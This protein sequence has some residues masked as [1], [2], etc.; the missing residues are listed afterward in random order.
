MARD[1]KALRIGAQIMG[2]VGEMFR[3]QFPG[4]KA[5]IVANS[6]GYQRFNNVINDSFARN[7]VEMYEPY[8]FTEEVICAEYEYVERLTAYLSDKPDAV[9]VSIGAGTINDLTKLSS[10]KAGLRYMSIATA[11]SMDGYAS[12][13]ASITYQGEKKDFECDAPQAILADTEVIAK[14]PSILT[15]AGY[16]DLFAKVTA[17]AD[18]ILAEELGVDKIDKYAWSISQGG[19]K[20]ALADP[21]GI[22]K[23]NVNSIEMLVEGLILGGFA[24]QS[25]RSSRP[26]SGA[27]HQF[28]HV[29]DM[30]NHTFDN[31]TPSHGFKVSIGMLAVTALYEQMLAT[32]MSK[33]DVDAAVAQWPSWEEMEK[34]V[35]EMFS[36]TNFLSIC[37]TET[38]AKH[39][40]QEEIAMQLTLLKENWWSIR[41]RLSTQLI[42]YTE[43]AHRLVLVGAPVSP[44]QIGITKAHLRETFRRAAFIRHRFTVLDVALRTGYMEQ[45]LD[46]IFGEGGIW[47][48]DEDSAEHK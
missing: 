22:K 19:L 30:E 38:K 20:E 12:H 5:L 3:S 47:E 40:S 28:S 17:G 18:W 23:G 24:M 29:W 9:P 10:Y 35:R 2:E 21:R 14:A 39:R 15:A 31:K 45:W 41:N 42:P 37:L 34:R 16:A 13:G 32:D 33:L 4:K 48:I 43:V 27:E 36:N 1:T 6:L 44:L 8:I 7:G 46:G 11:A 25:L 26:A